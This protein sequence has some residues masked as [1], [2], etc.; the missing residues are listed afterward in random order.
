MVPADENLEDEELLE[1]VN[2]GLIPII[3]MDSH[4]AEFWQQIFDHITVQPDIAVRTVGVM[5]VLPSTAADPNIGISDIEKLEPK[6]N[7]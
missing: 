6:K 5:Q 7:Y 4:K 3:V 1:M 2:A